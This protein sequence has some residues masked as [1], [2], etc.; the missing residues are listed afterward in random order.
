MKKYVVLYESA[1]GLVVVDY[2]TDHVSDA[3][4]DARLATYRLQ[5]AAYALALETILGKPVARVVFLF[6]RHGEAVERAI[7]DLTLACADA[8]QR[9]AA[10]TA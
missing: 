5:G 3:L 9:I 10:V 7:T 1:D 2:K 4:I 6:V 8:R